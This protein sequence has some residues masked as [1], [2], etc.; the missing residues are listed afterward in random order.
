MYLI[1]LAACGIEHLRMETLRIV[2]IQQY[3]FVSDRGERGP[4]SWCF[5]RRFFGNKTSH[6]VVFGIG[7]KKSDILDCVILI[8][9]IT[10]NTRP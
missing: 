4:K 3:Y 6:G 8:R 7:F 9:R 5:F 1:H 2:V 10:R